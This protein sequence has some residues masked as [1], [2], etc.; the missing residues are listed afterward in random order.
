MQHGLLQRYITSLIKETEIDRPLTP[1]EKILVQ[2]DRPQHALSKVYKILNMEGQNQDI[3]YIKKWEVEL[4]LEFPRKKWER[5][6]AGTHNMSLST[7]HQ[8]RNY[9]ILAR[10][11]KC[12][13]DLHKINPNNNETCWR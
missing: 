9:K 13:V 1:L 11:Y 4:G 2:K 6:I 7:K 8:D 5:A 3:P 10:W 12:P